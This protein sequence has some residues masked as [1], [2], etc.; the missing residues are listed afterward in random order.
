MKDLD[1]TKFCLG[2][3]LKHLP[4]GISVFQSANVQKILEKFNM[5]N[6]YSNKNSHGIKVLRN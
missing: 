6:S 3:Q 4:F 5:D 1:Q 2:L